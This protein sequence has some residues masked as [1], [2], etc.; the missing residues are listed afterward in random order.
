MCR[1]GRGNYVACIRK[2]R[3]YRVRSKVFVIRPWYKATHITKRG[4]LRPA[5]AATL[6]KVRSRAR[7]VRQIGSSPLLKDT[8]ENHRK[9]IVESFREAMEFKAYTDLAFHLASEF[10]QHPS[11]NYQFVLGHSDYGSHLGLVDT[12]VLVPDLPKTFL[13]I[14]ENYLLSFVHQNQVSL[15]EHLF[16]DLLKIMISHQPQSLSGKKQVDYSTVFEAESKEALIGKLIEKELNEIKYKNVCEWFG[17]LY[18]IA[19][20]PE[21]PKDELEKIAE[22][23][24]SRDILVHNAGVINQ[25]YIQKSGNAS[26]FSIGEKIDISGCYTRDVWALLSKSL[27]IVIDA[28][29]AK[30][31]K[32]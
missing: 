12:E 15:F 17:Y 13:P 14:K 10:S 3:I 9:R 22:A 8:L 23:K 6:T 18:K 20:I 25:V 28:V 21:L 7:I 30:H 24:A 31:S 4:T 19:S 2:R 11:M 27:L 29:I 5:A 32:T 16:F 1:S 26:R